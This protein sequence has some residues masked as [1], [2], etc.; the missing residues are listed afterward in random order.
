MHDNEIYIILLIEVIE[1][2][3]IINT[4]NQKNKLTL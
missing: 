1:N 4:F 3:C 2:I